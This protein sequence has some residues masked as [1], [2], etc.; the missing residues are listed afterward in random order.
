MRTLAELM[1]AAEEADG[2]YEQAVIASADRRGDYE[3][4]YHRALAEAEGT[5]Q[6]AKERFAEAVAAQEHRAFWWA[7]AAEKA[8]KTHVQ[9]LLGLLVASQS[10]SKHAGKLDGGTDW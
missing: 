3:L 7:E 1:D 6:A 2:L 8:A 9:V 4:A 10:L 5:S